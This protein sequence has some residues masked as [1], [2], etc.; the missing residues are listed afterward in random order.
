LKAR[1]FQACCE[2]CGRRPASLGDRAA[3]LPDFAAEG[4]QLVGRLTEQF[5]LGSGIWRA[6]Q[7]FRDWRL[8]RSVSAPLAPAALRLALRRPAV[9]DAR[10]ESAGRC[11]PGALTA[12]N[13]SAGAGAAWGG[14]KFVHPGVALVWPIDCSAAAR[15]Q[16]GCLAVIAFLLSVDQRSLQKLQGT[17]NNITLDSR[18]EAI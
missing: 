11:M 7:G 5:K 3:Q 14:G 13:W 18:P 4:T 15:G 10:W 2:H 17:S 16:R 8:G 12:S 9:P 6:C 1:D